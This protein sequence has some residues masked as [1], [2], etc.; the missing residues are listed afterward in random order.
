MPA[1]V[2]VDGDLAKYRDMPPIVLDSANSVNCS[3]GPNAARKLWAGPADLSMKVW[4][5]WDDANLY[6]AAKVVRDHF[7]QDQTGSRIF[8][9]D[10]FQLA[11]DTLSDAIPPE[12]GGRRGFDDDDYQYGLALTK[13]GP[14]SYCWIASKTN[15]DMAGKPAVFKPVI[16]RA[17][18]T[19]VD[20]EV[21]IPWSALAPLRPEAGAGFGFDLNYT[22]ANAPGDWQ[23]YWMQLTPGLSEGKDP[24][25]YRRFILVDK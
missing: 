7:I 20:Y 12:F 2:Q 22:A 4:L 17:S 6:F 19:V 21:A 24:S 11:F 1:G 10:G 16:V 3:A 15:A 18:D 9:Q 13:N 23:K 14:E 25:L 5:A 8:A